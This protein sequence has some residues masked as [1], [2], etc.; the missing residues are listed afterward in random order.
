MRL[1]RFLG[2]PFAGINEYEEKITSQNGEDGILREIFRSIGAQSRY[3]VEF[4]VGDGHECNG[5]HLIRRA[6]WSGLMLEGDPESFRRLEDAY[7]PFPRLQVGNRFI[8][9]ENIAAIFAEF[10]V[11]QSFDLLSIDIDGND[12]WVWRAL[13]AYRPRVVVIEYN[14][15]HPPPVRWVMRYDPN[16]RW[17]G[18]TYFGASLASLAALGREMGYGLVGTDTLGVNAFFA[19]R[20]L[21]SDLA[22]LRL[23]LPE[24]SAER[25]YHPAGF[26]N[27]RGRIGHPPGAGPFVRI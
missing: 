22:R 11:S 17:D 2:P 24:V 6:G 26:L 12:Y 16:H 27:Q 20:A 7:K 4:G 9:A 19:Q 18:T 25:A 3:L 1:R 13:S 10:R 8:T 15:A 5:A 14:A 23:G 21:L